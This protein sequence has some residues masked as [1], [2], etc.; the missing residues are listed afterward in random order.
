MD[1]DKQKLK[2]QLERIIES[3]QFSRSNVNVSLLKL[4]FQL[5][6]EGRKLKETTIGSEIFGKSYDPIKNDT[7]VRVYIHNLRKKLADYYATSGSSEEI[8]FEI[9]KGQYQISFN[10]RARKNPLINR[11]NL[12]IFLTIIIVS[13]FAITYLFKK[14][15]LYLWGEF[16]NNDFSN[17]VLI[18][19]HFTISTT[20]PTGGRGT[21]RD[22]SIN[23]EREFAEYIQEHPH[24]ASQ[25]IPNNF[26]Y[27]TKM[28]PYCTKIISEF[29]FEKDISF[30]LMLNSEWD[31]TK[32][33]S[34]NIIFIGQSKTMGFLE[35]L[36]LEMN[37]S[38]QISGNRIIY[39]D[40]D[41]NSSYVLESTLNE[42]VVDYT[43]VSHFQGSKGNEIALFISEHDIGVVHM[44]DYF[45]NTDSI[46]AFYDRHQ[47]SAD[48]FTAI[49]KVSGWER[50]GMNMELI[51][52]ESK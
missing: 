7:K 26:P 33:N 38:F 25:M 16:S 31:K 27:V 43:I 13:V 11:I 20:L 15:N 4:L 18:G 10:Y 41:K 37:P 22:F 1:I 51:S 6:L 9:E 30:S 52:V 5:T 3:D 28:G 35:N 23:S 12:L 19:D 40:K 2:D 45:T 21:F 36:F 8:I 48:G 14:E 44:V 50:T 39:T 24:L 17:T 47:L 32:V 46:K 49:F 42:N 29:L 34:E